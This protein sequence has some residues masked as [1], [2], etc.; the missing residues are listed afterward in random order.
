MWIYDTKTL[1]IVD[2][3]D[4][5][6]EAYGY[7]RERFLQL[8]IAQLRPSEDVP[9]LQR[10]VDSLDG[11]D[12]ANTSRAR[13][14][15]ARGEIIVVDVYGRPSDMAGSALRI[16]C[17]VD[18]TSEHAAMLALLDMKS[19]LE[20]AV[21]ERTAELE[22]RATVYR[23][24]TE[25]SPQIIWQAGQNGEVTYL[26]GAWH[27]MVGPPEGRWLGSGWL[28]ALHPD[29]FVP[30]RSAFMLASREKSTMRVRRRF[31]ARDGSYRTFLCVGA[32]V[33]QSDGSIE[34]W[35]GVDTDI[36]ELERRANS[37]KQL[38][39][40]L[41][42]MSYTVSHDLRAPVQVIKGFVDAVLSSQVGK[43][44]DDAREYLK[45]VR[46]NAG[47]M[48]ELIND[49]LALSSLSRET[50]DRAPFVLSAMVR[51]VIELVQ[52]RHPGRS[53]ECVTC[54]D[55]DVQADPRLF[56]VVLENLIDNAV[57]FSPGSGICSV[58]V[59]ACDEGDEAMIQVRDRGVGFPEELSPRLFRPFQRLHPIGQF[60]G[61]GIGLATVARIVQLHG[62]AITGRNR[63]G[64]GA[65]FEIR[66]PRR[67]LCT[68]PAPILPTETA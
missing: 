21:Q 9:A 41:E 6:L 22:A 55:V 10:V 48:D 66:I 63:I 54:G 26:N 28:A 20:T 50:L 43:V 7:S 30:V 61:T 68:M 37:L 11:R 34:S 29:D 58:Q 49:L 2:V 39:T 23:T 56:R 4:A 51:D 57:K 45:R 31:K 8:S 47:R 60:T 14:L 19:R 1:R 15:T 65:V 5:A 64:G 35:V 24:L 13:H 67:P 16:V 32:P 38:N 59:H 62:G 46:R 27:A 18:R 25:L 40:D 52:D 36:T 44:D 42:T 17:A 3:N 12:V 33:L 53:V